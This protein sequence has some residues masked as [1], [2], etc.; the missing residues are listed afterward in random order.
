MVFLFLSCTC[1]TLNRQDVANQRQSRVGHAE[2]GSVIKNNVATAGNHDCGT[3][4]YIFNNT[5][6]YLYIYTTPVTY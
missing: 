5:Y 2:Q 1:A 4:V 6:I 3:A